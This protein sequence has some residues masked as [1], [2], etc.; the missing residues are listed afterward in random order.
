MIEP[1]SSVAISMPALALLA[2][3]GVLAL[4]GRPDERLRSA[5]LPAAALSLGGGIILM[6]VGIT[7]RYLH[8]FYPALMVCGAVGVARIETWK[9]PPVVN[10][11]LTVLTAIS[12]WFN[13][14]FS[15]VHQRTIPWGV[16]APKRAQFAQ[17]QQF[18]HNRGSP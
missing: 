17:W 8:D 12:I 9:R 5:R 1:F 7:E 15:L 13:C 2:I 16:P 6:T 3:V 11:A 4:A 14:A 18:F 10:P